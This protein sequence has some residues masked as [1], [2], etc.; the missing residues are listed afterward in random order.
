MNC[1]Q[2][3]LAVVVRSG[4]GLSV[5]RLVTCIRLSDE[6]G[7]LDEDGTAEWGPVWETDDHSPTGYGQFHNLWLDSDL[8]PIRPQD[9]DAQDESFR[10]APAPE[11]VLA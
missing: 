11:K 1:K 2:G 8:R 7:L 4:K 10:W 6:P 5:G 3:D 9:D